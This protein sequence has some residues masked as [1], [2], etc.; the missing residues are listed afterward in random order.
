MPR[1]FV[2]VWPPEE[3]LD[4]L[5]ALDRPEVKGL[6]WTR[7]DQWHVTLR[8][9]GG[10]PDPAPVVEALAGLALPA[11]DA[12]LGPAV[13][14]FGRRIVHVPVAGLETIAAGVVAATAR[15]GS[16]PDDRPFHGHITL[17]RAADRGRVDLRPFTGAIVGAEWR[18][19]A[20]CLVES[21]LSPAGA[22][23]EVIERFALADG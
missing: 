16:P 19:D 15:L 11:G 7:R 5:A 12:V 10:V 21:R 17:A 18:V 14:R 9:L 23:Y 2:A 20:V 13:D 3:V 22:R 6:R 1:L 8:F 4:R